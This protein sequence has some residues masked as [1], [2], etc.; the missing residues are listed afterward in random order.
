M[1]VEETIN[2]AV[3]DLN[4]VDV[5]SN[6]GKTE[7]GELLS[8]SKDKITLRV[9]EET[10]ILYRTGEKKGDEIWRLKDE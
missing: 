8:F 3:E 9:D 6:T 4:L 7:T 10:K 1:S 5:L 2:E